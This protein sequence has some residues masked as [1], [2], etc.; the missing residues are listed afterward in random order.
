MFAGIEIHARQELFAELQLDALAVALDHEARALGLARGLQQRHLLEIAAVVAGRRQADRAEALGDVQ[1]G[2]VEAAGAG[3]A[4]FEQ[5][6]GEEAQV[7]LDPARGVG[8][9]RTWS[10]RG[11]L[12]LGQFQRGAL[13]RGQGEHD[14]ADTMQADSG[15]RR[16]A[17][18][19][20]AGS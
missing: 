1:R 19:T 8:C 20:T 5:V 17:D 13:A 3:F 7:G 14:A 11:G 6:V 18:S 4:A 15:R 16:M 12:R 10:R 9:R 2:E